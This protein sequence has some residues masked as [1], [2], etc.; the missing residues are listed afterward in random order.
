[1]A[2]PSKNWTCPF[3]NRPQTIT[4]GQES[5]QNAYLGLREHK[6][7]HA[8]LFIQA[9]ACANPECRE[10]T[11]HVA[12]TQGE[13]SWDS[14][15]PKLAV[16]EYRLRPESSA[17]P[18]P[19]YIP[20]AIREDYYEACRIRDLSP[21]SS[22]TLARR[23]LQGMIRDFCGIRKGRLFDEIEELRERVEQGNSPQGVVHESVDAIDHVRSIGNIGAHMENDVN[24]IIEIDPGEAQAL[25]E[26]AEMLLAEWYV[27]RKSREDRF[28][29]VAAI[30]KQKKQDRAG[31]KTKAQA[32]DQDTQ[33]G[34]G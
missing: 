24:L 31:K 14:Y 5:R 22:A 1:V 25:I 20:K 27:A 10:I 7:G 21:K 26:L 29:A 17:K 9:F 11:L 18:Q 30:G 4:D 15:R 16:Q 8:G 33:G 13:G 28:A 19:D 23:C 2:A 3:C 6:Y 12:F 34:E 32:A